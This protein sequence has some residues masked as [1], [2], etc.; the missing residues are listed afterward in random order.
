MKSVTNYI[1]GSMK[2]FPFCIK[3]H[4][5]IS[6]LKMRNVLDVIMLPLALLNFLWIDFVKHSKFGG[7]V[8]SFR[9]CDNEK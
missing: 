5:C 2:R 9:C 6:N 1:K 3:M 8:C 7:G 4:D